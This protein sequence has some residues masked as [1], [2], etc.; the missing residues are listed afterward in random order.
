VQLEDILP[1]W[2]LQLMIVFQ[3]HIGAIRRSLQLTVL[4]SNFLSFNSIL[5]QLEV[6]R[7]G[8]N[9]RSYC[10]FNSILVQL[11][12][13][14]GYNTLQLSIR[15]QFHIGAIRSYKSSKY[16]TITDDRFN[17]I[18][19]QLEAVWFVVMIQLDGVSIPY[20]CN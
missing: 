16:D 11:E 8:W 13:G 17:S 7:S 4:A 5:V 1:E 20:W 3:F 18:L 15:F 6:I 14:E 9:E 19:V 2:G 10:G 12:G